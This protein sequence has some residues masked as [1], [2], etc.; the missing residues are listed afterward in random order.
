MYLSRAIPSKAFVLSRLAQQA[1]AGNVYSQHQLLWQLFPDQSARDFLFRYEQ[2]K[3]GVCYYLL[4][5]TEPEPGLEGIE[6]VTK[7]FRPQITPGDRLAYTLRANPTR[8][9][10]SDTPG[11]RGNRVDV[12]MHAKYQAPDNESQ[13][14]MRTIQQQAAQDWLM[15]SDRQQRLGIEFVSTPEV[16]EHRQHQVYKTYRNNSRTKPIQ[17]TS[18]N[19][20]GV[21]QVVHPD[22]FLEQLAQGIG[23]AK[24]MGCGLMM[25]RRYT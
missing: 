16:T 3:A 23:R 11:K 5:Q 22:R 9:L 10:K 4:S 7:P 18:V 15:E 24:A 6:V 21:L 8:M 1:H 12:L 14:D 25:I 17:F 20:Q 13:A 19:Y 2:G